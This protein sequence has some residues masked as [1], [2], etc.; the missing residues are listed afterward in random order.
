MKG[1]WASKDEM[2]ARSFFRMACDGG[3][4]RSCDLLGELYEQG[5]GGSGDDALA[6]VFYMKPCDHG[7]G[8]ACAS[9]KDL[10]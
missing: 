2:R 7:V 4:M 6:R 1:S 8:V 5:K 9:L 10:H 3:Q